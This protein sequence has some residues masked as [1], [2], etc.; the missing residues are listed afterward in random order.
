M[1][2]FVLKAAV[3]ELHD[4]VLDEFVLR[5]HRVEEVHHLDDVWATLEHT[6]DLVLSGDYISCLHR[7]FK[8]DSLFVVFVNCLENVACITIKML[9]KTYQR[10]RCPSPVLE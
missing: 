9:N 6:E 4:R 1:A 7:T 2:E 5:G 8:G 10:L 3:T